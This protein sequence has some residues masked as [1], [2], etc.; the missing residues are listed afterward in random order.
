MVF[1]GNTNINSYWLRSRDI[2]H[3]DTGTTVGAISVPAQTW[4][5]RVVSV[6]TVAFQTGGYVDV[7]DGT[8]PDGWITSTGMLV[9]DGTLALRAD[10]SGAY[11]SGKGYITADTIDV[12]LVDSTSGHMY[13]MAHMLPLAAMY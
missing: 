6:V 7:G 4:V 12:Q 3:A 2:T 9:S 11:R 10:T 8:D 5:D 13:I 1:S